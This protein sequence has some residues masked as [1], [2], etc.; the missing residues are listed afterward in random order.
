MINATVCH[1]LVDHGE[2]V[3]A[4]D[5]HAGAQ[6]KWLALPSITPEPW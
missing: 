4:D 5:H 6:L 3:N 1:A 2:E